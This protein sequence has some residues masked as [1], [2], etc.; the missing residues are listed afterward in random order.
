MKSIFFQIILLLLLAG[1]ITRAQSNMVSERYGNFNPDSL[2]QISVTGKVI[3]DSSM[4]NGMYYLDIN[5]DNKPDYMLNFGPYW[6]KP[7]SSSA[8]RPKVGDTITLSGGMYNGMTEYLPMIVVYSI[9]GNF[10]RTPYDS[11]WNEMGQHSMMGGNQ[12]MGMGYAFGLDHDSLISL[13]VSGRVLVDS[14]FMYNH[15][16]LD[17]NNDG[18]PDYLLNFGSPW[19]ESLSGIKLPASGDN[20]SVTGW[21]AGNDMMNMIVVY[22][23]N[24]QI[25]RD[26]SDLGNDMGGWIQKN[27][28]Q[29]QRFHNP[30]DTTDWMEV[31]PG[32][33]QGGMMGGGGMMPDSL[34]CQLLEVFPQDVPSDSNQNSMAAF[35]VGTFLPNGMN[36]L[37]QSGNMGGHMNFG[38]TVR[39][40]FHYNNQQTIGY[41]IKSGNIKVKY[42][43]NLT[44]QWI[45]ASN[46]VIN[47]SNNTISISQNEVSNFYIVSAD[48][49][50]GVSNNN[51]Y[52]PYNFSLNQNYPN[53][54]N[55]STVIS[56]Q[57]STPSK[58]SLKVY[59]ILG[60]EVAT[61]VNEEK[62]AG[63]YSVNFN[64]NRL[65]SGV[66]FYRMQAGSFAETKKLILLK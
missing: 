54:F 15:L 1:V 25:W 51:N 19:Y 60:D 20:I 42:W 12:H 18:T 53:P 37:S 2:K 43:D 48:K 28:S 46:T 14:T 22:K 32:W 35:E 47:S 17:T 52:V 10:W 4:I 21:K 49:I 56:Y 62:P 40:Q 44:N 16:Y 33:N 8:A 65:A 13:T 63:R 6:Y 5:N 31:N 58:V 9:N 36:G 26:S 38:S 59:D 45:S 64:A 41:N 57:L 7:D 24:G 50:T 34:Y 30:F 11:Y 29:S 23:L 39:F 27:M 66:Y 61:L 55:P 3:A